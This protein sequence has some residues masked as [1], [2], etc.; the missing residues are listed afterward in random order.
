[1]RLIRM[2]LA[3]VLI[4]LPV[5]ARAEQKADPY[6]LL[7]AADSSSG[8]YMQ[9]FEQLKKYC[10]DT[11]DINLEKIENT[12]GAVGNLDAVFTNKA[13]AGFLHSDVVMLA[14]KGN[15]QYADFKTLLSCCP[16]DIQIVALRNSRAKTGGTN[17]GITTVNEKT[18]EFNSLQDLDGYDVAAAGGG[19]KTMQQL[20]SEGRAGFNPNAF[21]KGGD[22]LP[23]L[24]EGKVH[25]VIF[26]GAAPLKIIADLSRSEYK[27]IPIGDSIA[28]RL[29]SMYRSTQITYP[30]LLADQVQTMAPMATMVTRPVRAPIVKKALAGLRKC[31]AENLSLIQD[32]VGTHPKWREAIEW[33]RGVWYWLP[34]EG[35]QDPAQNK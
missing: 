5:S 13:N 27:L 10:G 20:V 22:L 33:D 24:K 11:P 34:L 32:T 29:K 3:V 12:G 30:N 21:E 8:I 26:V 19:V 1:M 6:K 14:E 18:K 16:E 35:D 28:A 4:T 25:A 9:L 7:V 2:A 23:A 31:Y 15:K 17:L